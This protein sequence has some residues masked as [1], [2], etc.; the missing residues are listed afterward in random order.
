MNIGDKLIILV[1]NPYGTQLNINNV[2]MI[3]NIDA[4]PSHD[5]DILIVENVAGKPGRFWSLSSSGL[6]SQFEIYKGYDA[7]VNL[8]K[9]P[10]DTAIKHEEFKGAHTLGY[11]PDVDNFWDYKEQQ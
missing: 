3:T 6:H 10:K 9:K 8:Y 2:V 7:Q 11:D 1:D 5:S 4:H